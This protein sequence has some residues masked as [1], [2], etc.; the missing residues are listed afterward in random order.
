MK[1]LV[2]SAGPNPDVTRSNGYLDAV[3][4]ALVARGHEV[5]QLHMAGL[6][7]WYRGLHV[8]RSDGAS[9]LVFTLRNS[10]VYAGTPPGAGTGTAQPEREIRASGRL[11]AAVRS[12]LRE[13][14]PEVVHIQNL[15]G[16]PANL[17]DV[18]RSS[19]AA[20]VLTAHD[21]LSICPTTHLF[22]P[23][24]HPCSLS[25]D[26]LT[27]SQCCTGAQRYGFFRL[28][29]GFDRQVDQLRP[30]SLGWKATARIRNGLIHVNRAIRQV[31]ATDEP[32]RQRFDA[33]TAMLHRLD[34]VHCISHVQ[35]NRLQVATGPLT[36]LEVLPLVPPSVQ[37]CEPVARHPEAG[38]KLRFSVL[39]VLP[40]RTEKGWDYL[41]TVINRLEQRRQDFQVDWFA[42]GTDTRTIR[43][44][45]R[46]TQ[47][48]LDRIAAESDFCIIPSIWHET[49]GFTGV[50]ML[51]R[52]V[53]LICS[54]R[55]GVSEG[56]RDGST[57]WLFDPS[58][59]EAL[60]TILERVLAAPRLAIDF[61]RAQ[62]GVCSTLSTFPE[63]VAALDEM[64]SRAFEARTRR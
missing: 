45:G 35:A 27:C 63:H 16:L 60:E 17:I 8:E 26:E 48:D 54:N 28:R 40:G 61:R 4:A 9:G 50:E 12:L 41:R 13:I 2:V 21:Y 15:F 56:V 24:G 62:A 44:H 55:C 64:L 33:M 20:V 31:V 58:T 7:P 18:F 22:R 36:R 51:S 53:P 37:R 32:Y 42:D 29:N 14:H 25:R 30:G 19:G 23:E 43:H 49:L 34:T 46:Y 39:N 52:G 1:L 11:R 3:P 59:P 10:R 5:V 57:G 47:A 6:G 38:S